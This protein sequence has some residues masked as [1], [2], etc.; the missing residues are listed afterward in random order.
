MEMGSDLPSFCICLDTML[1]AIESKRPKCISQ[2]IKLFEESCDFIAIFSSLCN[3]QITMH[4]YPFIKGGQKDLPRRMTEITIRNANGGG[5]NK[6]ADLYLQT[7]HAAFIPLDPEFEVALAQGTKKGNTSRELTAM[8]KYEMLFPQFAHISQ[9]L[10]LEDPSNGS[11]VMTMVIKNRHE[12]RLKRTNTFLKK[13][14][15]K[16]I[17]DDDDNN[18]NR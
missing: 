14:A 15:P 3:A 16:L 12:K 17:Q 9:E 7:Y 2:P 1:S 5:D 13:F 10:A 8:A 18:N 11:P 4:S 6:S